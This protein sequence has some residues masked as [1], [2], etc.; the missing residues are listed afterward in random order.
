MNDELAC[1]NMGW[2][3]FGGLNLVRDGYHNQYWWRR[4]RLL[5]RQ[6]TC[7]KCSKANIKCSHYIKWIH[8]LDYDLDCHAYFYDDHKSNPSFQFR[9]DIH[10]HCERVLQQYINMVEKATLESSTFMTSSWNFNRQNKSDHDVISNSTLASYIFIIGKCHEHGI[11]AALDHRTALAWWRRGTQNLTPSSVL[12]TS[13]LFTGASSSR[14]AVS[15]SPSESSSVD[16]KETSSNDGSCHLAL[17]VAYGNGTCGVV[18]DDQLAMKYA[19]EAISFGNMKGHYHLAIAYKKARQPIL[20]KH[21]MLCAAESGFTEAQYRLGVNLIQHRDSCSDDTNAKDGV[22]WL[23][24]ASTSGHAE[25]DVQL[26]ILYESNGSILPATFVSD[27]SSSTS[28]PTNMPPTETKTIIMS[29]D[30]LAYRCYERSASLGSY[31]GA[32]HMALCWSHKDRIARYGDMLTETK[33]TNTISYRY[34]TYALLGPIAKE[35]Q[36]YRILQL[37]GLLLWAEWTMGSY[38]C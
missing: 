2:L 28:T 34:L 30:K 38:G 32:H 19:N 24:K 10:L 29:G 23:L 12:S 13:A 8:P 36:N 17:A 18:C 9:D 16:S 26:G 11:G 3:Y 33:D 1:Y 22:Y 31:R 6:R 7:I 35:K 21:H 27:A 4:H 37:E 5:S 25:A 20:S 15:T 14:S